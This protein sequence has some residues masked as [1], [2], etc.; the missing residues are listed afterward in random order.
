MSSLEAFQKFL[1]HNYKSTY[2]TL[3]CDFCGSFMGTQKYNDYGF[4]FIIFY[5][6]YFQQQQISKGFI[7][8][9]LHNTLNIT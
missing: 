3:H 1:R 5:I 2:C 4:G 7:H 9:Q 8:A 6:V